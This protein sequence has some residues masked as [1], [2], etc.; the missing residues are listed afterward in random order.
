MLNKEA[1]NIKTITV[2]NLP[3]Q[4]LLQRPVGIWK[5]IETDAQISTFWNMGSIGYQYQG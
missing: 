5:N 3:T 4:Y 2:L 1:A